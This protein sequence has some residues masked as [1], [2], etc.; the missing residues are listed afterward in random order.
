MSKPLGV[1]PNTQAKLDSDRH[2]PALRW[3]LGLGLLASYV[4]V[5]GFRQPMTTFWMALALYGGLHQFVIEEV[6]GARV[7]DEYRWS[8]VLALATGA[9]AW[10]AHIAPAGSMWEALAA[11]EW[12]PLGLIALAL[13]FD[14]RIL[15]PTAAQTIGTAFSSARRAKG[16]RLEQDP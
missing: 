5:A 13:A 4:G 14:R 7:P 9:L 10:V 8:L 1:D 2:P 15:K 11:R 6:P 16:E 12:F 3:L